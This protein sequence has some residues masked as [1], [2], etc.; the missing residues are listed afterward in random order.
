MV[1]EEWD[2]DTSAFLREVV[3]LKSEVIK[4]CLLC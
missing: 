3:G 1:G 4:E 2:T